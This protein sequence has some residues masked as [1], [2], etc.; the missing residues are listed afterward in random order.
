MRYHMLTAEMIRDAGKQAK[1]MGHS[2]VDCIH[3]LLVM[4]RQSGSVGQLLRGMGLDLALTE[5]LMSVLY[6]QGTAGLPLPQGLSAELSRVLH[7]AAE[8]ACRTKAREI[9]PL[10]LLVALARSEAGTVTEVLELCGVG[11]D[12]LFTCA[13]DYL[14][15]EREAPAKPQKEA[16]ATKLLD[17]FSEDL[18]TKASS[19]D[20][21]IGRDREIDAVIGIL[22]RKNKNNPALVGEPGVG[23]TAIAEGLAQRMAVGNVPPQLKDKRLISLNMANLVAGTK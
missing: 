20:P 8:E 12:D 10:H 13:V 6:G 7:G 18:I 17:Q 5:K 16:V 19:M 9:E 2:C 22:C 21:V 11:K 23:K 15:W 14:R 4:L 3:L 1:T